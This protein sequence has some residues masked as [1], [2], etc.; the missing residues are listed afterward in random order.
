MYQSWQLTSP[1]K[2]SVL[3]LP[4]PRWSWNWSRKRNDYKWKIKI[5]NQTSILWKQILKIEFD[6]FSIWNVFKVASYAITMKLLV[7]SLNKKQYLLHTSALNLQLTSPFLYHSAKRFSVTSTHR[8]Q[9]IFSHISR[10]DWL[11]TSRLGSSHD[12]EIVNSLFA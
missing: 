11:S 7:H 6:N 5:C 8:L 10:I 12:S 1:V 9:N 3:F 2:F 4:F